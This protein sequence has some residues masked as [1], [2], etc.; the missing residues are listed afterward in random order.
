M[1]IET[2][3]VPTDFS[4][5]AEKAFA[6]AIDFAKAFGSRIELVHVYDFGTWV[7]AYEVT[8]ADE[9]ASQVR[10]AASQRLDGWIDRVKQQ[11]IEVSAQ[12]ML[13]TPSRAIVQRAEEIKAGLIVMG[14]RGL[15][16]VK[17][18]LLGS[19]AERTIRA[20]RCPVLTVATDAVTETQ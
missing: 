6:V 3:L 5:Q 11:G 8:F 19:V 14:T 4:K 18:V 12:L 10:A 9:V 2:I 7:T 17:H 1:K 13:G 16:A 20:A 15:G